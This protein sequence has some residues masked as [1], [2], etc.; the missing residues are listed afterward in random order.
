MYILEDK[1]AGLD[2]AK[3]VMREELHLFKSPEPSIYAAVCNETLRAC[4][5][6]VGAEAKKV[7][8]FRSTSLTYGLFRTPYWS[9]GMLSMGP[10]LQHAIGNFELEVKSGRL[11]LNHALDGEHVDAE[12]KKLK[13]RE[14]RQLFT[15]LS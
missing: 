4:T 13:D 3:E 14:S 8:K 7:A 15:H 6:H 11:A 12:F 5:E 10:M 2:T 1:A 9:G